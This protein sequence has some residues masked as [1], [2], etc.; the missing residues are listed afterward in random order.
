MAKPLRVL[1]SGSGIA[2]SVFAS[3]LLRGLPNAAITIIERALSPRLTGASVDI[4]SSAVNIIK[5]MGVEP[6]IRKNTTK[7]AGTQFVSTDGKPIATFAATGRSDVQSLTSEYEIF[8]GTLAKLFLEPIKDKVKLVFDQTISSYNQDEHSVTVTFA[9]GTNDTYDLVVA[10][11]GLGS[12]LRGMVMGTK[13]DAQIYDEGV[14]AAWFTIDKDILGG[15]MA[16]WYNLDRGRAVLLRPDPAGRTRANL[17]T[18]TWNSNTE[19]KARL[20]KALSEGNDSFTRLMAELF[21]DEKWL[22]PQVLEGMRT[23]DDFYGSMFAQVRC[24]RLRQGRVVLLGDAGYATPG[25]GTSLAITGGYVLAGELLTHYKGAD[26][27]STG[28]GLDTAVT[29]YEKLMLAFAKASQGNDIAMQ[30]VNPQ[31]N[32]G[33]SLRNAFLWF[34]TSVKLDKLVMLASAKLGFTEKPFPVPAYDWPDEV[35]A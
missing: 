6:E 24:D 16:K 17:L 19:M 1:V 18:V 5:W 22:L 7:E 25:F 3:C 20:N 11:D 10:A 27:A 8:R 32:W 9:D 13:S 23:S 35:S 4:R 2:G 15:Q 14:H 30:L 26:L 34:V 28:K 29:N 21:A 12:K 31:S 33:L